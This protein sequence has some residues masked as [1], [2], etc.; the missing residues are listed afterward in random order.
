ME[1][2]TLQINT[3]TLIFACVRFCSWASLY[4]CAYHWICRI[5]IIKRVKKKNVLAWSID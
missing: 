4:T 3:L 1:L 2:I 5:I